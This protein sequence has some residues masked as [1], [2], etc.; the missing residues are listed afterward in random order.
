M[1]IQYEGDGKDELYQC[2]C[3]KA[4]KCVMIEP[5]RGCEV[6]GEWLIKGEE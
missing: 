1:V 6:Y 5:C 2:P 3:C 4:T